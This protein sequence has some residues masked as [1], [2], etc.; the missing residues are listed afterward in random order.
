MTYHPKILTLVGEKLRILMSSLIQI[1]ATSL[2]ETSFFTPLFRS[3]KN[4]KDGNFTVINQQ[5]VQ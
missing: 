5:N 1:R 3:A 4:R 2:F